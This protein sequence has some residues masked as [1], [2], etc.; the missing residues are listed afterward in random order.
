MPGV[1]IFIGENEEILYVGKAIDLKK[2]VSSYFKTKDLGEKTK[3]LVS[4]IKKIRTIE[5]ESELESF[6]LEERL[7]KKHKPKYNIK[8]I[9]GKSYPFIKITVKDKYPA[10][11]LMRKKLNDG[12]LYFGPYSSASS[13]KTVLKI[14][15]RIFPYQSTTNH[16]NKK[17]LYF[18][19]GLCPCPSVTNDTDYKKTIKHII[20]F[21]E[22][23]SSKVVG[24]LEKER[25]SFSKSEDFEKAS[26]IQKKIDS[27]KLVTSPFYKPFE[28]EQNPNLR[29]DVIKDNLNSFKEILN[30][31]SVLV[32]NLTRI[33]CYDISNTSGSNATGSMVVFT[34]GEKD[35]SSYRRFKIKKFYNNKP[36]DFAMMQ[37]VLERRL[38]RK[39]WPTPSL[40]IVDERDGHGPSYPYNSLSHIKAK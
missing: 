25:D 24:D 13:V 3:V 4:Q 34:N 15:R 17:C 20:N 16:A 35:S 11:F 29:T 28:Y 21:L 31:N 14:I 37:E 7:I 1:Y 36:N 8:L 39:D 10:V 12:S 27:I 23:N 2:R 26:G 30:K 33:E 40:I 9:D 19:L 6:L 5:V 22:G 18:H 38:K 32:N